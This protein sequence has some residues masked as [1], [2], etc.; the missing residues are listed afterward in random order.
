MFLGS[1]ARFCQ[2]L[3]ECN[4]VGFAYFCSWCSALLFR[5]RDIAYLIQLEV[6]CTIQIDVAEFLQKV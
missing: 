6:D 3:C 2:C 5:H 1:M 4:A